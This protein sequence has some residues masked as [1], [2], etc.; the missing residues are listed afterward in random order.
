MLADV[1][2]GDREVGVCNE[3]AGACVIRNDVNEGGSCKVIACSDP[4]WES[5]E[6]PSG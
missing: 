1:T 6:E 4:D 5:I 3:V 2:T